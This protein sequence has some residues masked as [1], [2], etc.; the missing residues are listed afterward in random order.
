MAYSD[1]RVGGG[2]AVCGADGV[3][4]RLV[5]PGNGTGLG[6]FGDPCGV[7]LDCHPRPKG[8]GVMNVRCVACGRSVEGAAL[9]LCQR[10]RDTADWQL[11]G[12]RADGGV[13]TGP[14]V[15]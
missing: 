12:H 15:A 9:V 14:R 2:C 4:G 1:C 3:P 11:R 8:V 6:A 5:D 10:C 13:A 7:A